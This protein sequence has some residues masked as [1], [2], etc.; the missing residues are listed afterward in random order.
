MPEAGFLTF[1]PATKPETWRTEKLG[2]RID[3][4]AV[5]PA[6]NRQLHAVDAVAGQST[7][8]TSFNL[9]TLDAPLLS[10]ASQPFLVFTRNQPI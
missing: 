5:V 6:G 1:A 7:S 9:R 10:P 3:P 4:T 2:L 8:G